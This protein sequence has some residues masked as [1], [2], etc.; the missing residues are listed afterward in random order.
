MPEIDLSKLGNAMRNAR[1]SRGFTQ[2]R[3]SDVSGVSVRHIA[4]IEKGEV[5]PSFD[6]MEK[7]IT[8]LGTSFD[9]FYNP[10]SDKE[11]IELQEVVGLYKACPPIGKRLIAATARALANELMD[12]NLEPESEK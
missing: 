2:E 9:A 7:L 3:L 11:A 4:K 1:K 8:A 6:I 5:N 12:T 10:A